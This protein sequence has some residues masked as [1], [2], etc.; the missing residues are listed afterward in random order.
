MLKYVIFL[1]LF[2]KKHEE[3]EKKTS[4]SVSFNVFFFI[5]SLIIGCVV[6]GV[7]TTL[8]LLMNENI[9]R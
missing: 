3:D 8:K 7:A 6:I 4:V 1:F 9:S 2:S 5:L